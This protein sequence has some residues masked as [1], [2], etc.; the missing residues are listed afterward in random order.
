M[1][2]DGFWNPPKKNSTPEFYPHL[3]GMVRKV[4]ESKTPEERE[5]HLKAM[6]THPVYMT[7][8][9]DHLVKRAKRELK[10]EKAHEEY[11]RMTKKHD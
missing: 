8:A 4:E 9:P 11:E 10:A 5:E 3:K 1:A 2:R 6:R 7:M